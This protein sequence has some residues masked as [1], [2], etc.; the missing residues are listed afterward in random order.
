MPLD[1]PDDMECNCPQC[2]LQ[3]VIF[4]A[5]GE[6]EDGIGYTI[7]PLQGLMDLTPTIAVLLSA[8]SAPDMQR[9]LKMLLDARSLV[10]HAHVA[11]AL[12][13]P[14]QGHA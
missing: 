12:M 1:A 10:P 6:T 4:E 7:D 14:A 5:I 2:C 9:W 3:R 13:G 11:N 8:L